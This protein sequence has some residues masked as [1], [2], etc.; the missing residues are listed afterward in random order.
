MTK[1]YFEKNEQAVLKNFRWSVGKKEKGMG[2]WLP[3]KVRARHLDQTNFAAAEN[4]RIRQHA[5]HHSIRAFLRELVQGL[6]V[7]PSMMAPA[8]LH[9][10]LTIMPLFFVP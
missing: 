2:T 9:A 5:D 4:L 6:I 7:T 10:R 8:L 1:I 3:A